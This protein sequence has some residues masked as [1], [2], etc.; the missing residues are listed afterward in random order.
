[1]RHINNCNELLEA[2]VWSFILKVSEEEWYFQ[3]DIV[4]L[5]GYYTTCNTGTLITLSPAYEHYIF[6]ITEDLGDSTFL[7]TV[8]KSSMTIDQN[9]GVILPIYCRREL[10]DTIKG[11]W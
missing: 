11:L 8:S 7:L 5:D 2:L 3:G 9:L 1:M 4:K 10:I 6:Y